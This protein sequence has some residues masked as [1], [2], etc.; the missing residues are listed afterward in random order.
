MSNITSLL[1]SN[2]EHYEIFIKAGKVAKQQKLPCYL[3]GG[4]IRDRLLNRESSDI[5]I[6]V[7][8]DAIS[9][10]KLLGNEIGVPKLRM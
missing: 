3:V 7:E 6:M 8:G 2:S 10:A 1:D 5:D 9:Y 4:Y